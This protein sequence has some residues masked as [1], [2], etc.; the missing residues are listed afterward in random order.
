MHSVLLH[1]CC[2]PC[3]CFPVP[4]LRREG[5]A[6]TGYFSNHNIHPFTEWRE[7]RQAMEQYAEIDDLPVIYDDDYR[8][9]E[10]FRTVSFRENRRCLMCYQMRLEQTAHIARRGKFDGFST[11]LLVSK[12]QR[13]DLIHEL[14]VA[15]GE[16]YGVPFVYR[17]FREGFKESG[18]RSRSMGLYRQQYCGCLYSE[19]ERYAPRDI[20]DHVKRERDG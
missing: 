15:A 10:Y 13:H 6:V 5:F 18:E 8:P 11:S 12:H 16:K 4:A 3:A 14:G 9:A 7:R 1:C 17:D 19:I 2:A 20:R